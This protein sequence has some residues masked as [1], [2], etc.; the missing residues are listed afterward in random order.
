MRRT[1]YPGLFKECV[2]ANVS[3]ASAAARALRALELPESA[4][5]FDTNQKSRRRGSILIDS[6]FK[7]HK[8]K[9]NR[10]VPTQTAKRRNLDDA[11]ME[12]RDAL[13]M[14]QEEDLREWDQ[15]V[16]Q[17]ELGIFNESSEAW[18]P[19]R[20]G[21]DNLHAESRRMEGSRFVLRRFTTYIDARPEVV[22]RAAAES[23]GTS[24]DFR[25]GDRN[26]LELRLW[27]GLVTRIW[28]RGN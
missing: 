12:W 18:T 23:L 1:I 26:I 24:S 27:H 28:C 6:S 21:L 20:T 22:Y 19:M 11:A 10:V 3:S 13:F 2:V 7:K 25:F 14:T 9:K 17:E 15:R 16:R 4:V 5:L 8:P